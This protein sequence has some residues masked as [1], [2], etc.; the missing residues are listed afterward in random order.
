MF[1]AYCGKPIAQDGQ[2]CTNCGKPVTPAAHPDLS[3][4]TDQQ[5]EVRLLQAYDQ[6]LTDFG[7]VFSKAAR[8]GKEDL[9][10]AVSEY[11]R[12]V[13]IYEKQV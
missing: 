6:E 10:R 8:T 1:C 3:T 12:K 7:A 9:R 2:Y 5:R 11:R 13:D 4:S